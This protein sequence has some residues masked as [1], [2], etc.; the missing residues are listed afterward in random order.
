ME[1]RGKKIVFLGDSITEGIGC[2]SVE[3]CFVEQIAA[4]SGAICKNFGV[5]GTRIAKQYEPSANPQ[6]NQYF[7][8]RIPS[9][10]ED[11]DLVIVFGGVNDYA[12]GDAPMGC[13]LDR[14]PDTFLGALH[15]LYRRL[16]ERY[17]D[18]PI[19]VFTPLHRVGE[20]N[21]Y[22]KGKPKPIGTLKEYVDAIRQ[23]AEFYSLPVLDLYASSGLQPCVS[24]QREKYFHDAAHPND[25]GHRVLARKMLDFFLK[26][27]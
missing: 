18:K 19:V 27:L 1:L 21:P 16:I 25:E 17:P 2:S 12:S 15:D 11:A 6:M 22:G 14:V 3:H 9:M 4:T 5:G 8:S 13:M 7:A 23:V 24:A 20:E 26:R 10:D